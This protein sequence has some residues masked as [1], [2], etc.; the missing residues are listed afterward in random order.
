MVKFK[1]DFNESTDKPALEF[2]Y[3][4][5]SQELA[6][7]TFRRF[8]ELANQVNELEE[9]VNEITLT[10]STLESGITIIQLNIVPK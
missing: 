4:T 2:Q 7:K 1:I 9:K 8:I 5:A 6:E 3:N 10:Q